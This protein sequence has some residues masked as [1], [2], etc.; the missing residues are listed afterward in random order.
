MSSSSSLIS[1]HFGSFWDRLS[2]WE[3]VPLSPRFFRLSPARLRR[4]RRRSSMIIRWITL[5]LLLLPFV[6]PITLFLIHNA[7]DFIIRMC[8]SFSLLKICL[9]AQKIVE[10]KINEKGIIIVSDPAWKK[11]KKKGI[12]MNFCSNASLL[13]FFLSFPCF[14]F[15]LIILLDIFSETKRP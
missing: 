7:P 2:R 4:F 5:T 1:F 3:L 14:F 10:K 11:K 15:F 9:D 13:V 12:S 8:F 6:L